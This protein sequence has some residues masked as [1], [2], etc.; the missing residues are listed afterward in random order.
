[1]S[2]KKPG[3]DQPTAPDIT[4]P[5]A[6][7]LPLGVIQLSFETLPKVGNPALPVIWI[8]ATT[9]AVRGDLPVAMLRFYALLPEAAV[10]TL[11]MQT[12]IDHL[13]GL[14]DLI[15]KTIDYYPTRPIDVQKTSAQSK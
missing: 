6:Q 15:G 11:R 4:P 2:R 9:I 10:E 13:R 3:K 1:M 7:Q 12:S 8:D 14:V 5:P